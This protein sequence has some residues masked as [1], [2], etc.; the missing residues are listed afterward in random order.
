M[1]IE[2]SDSPTRAYCIDVTERQLPTEAEIKSEQNK[3]DESD[4]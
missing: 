1:R 3:Q 2:V 4:A